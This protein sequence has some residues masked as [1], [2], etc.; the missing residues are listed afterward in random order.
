MILPSSGRLV[1]KL[2]GGVV[3]GRIWTP[4]DCNGLTGSGSAITVADVYP[5]S[6]SGPIYRRREPRWI[7]ARFFLIGSKASA[8]A[9]PVHTSGSEAIG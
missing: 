5:A 4:P 7:S 8:L 1:S 6:P 9:L 3:C 2:K